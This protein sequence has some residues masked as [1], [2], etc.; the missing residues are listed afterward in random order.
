MNLHVTHAIKQNYSAYETGLSVKRDEYYQCQDGS[1]CCDGDYCR[2]GVINGVTVKVDIPEFIQNQNYR[3]SDIDAYGV[4]RI[5]RINKIY[6]SDSWGFE[7]CGGYY[8]EELSGV[9]I[10][11]EVYS[12]IAESVDKLIPLNPI[13]A[14]IELLLELEYEHTPDKYKNRK[15]IEAEVDRQTLGS[16]NPVHTKKIRDF[17]HYKNY[18][19]YV[20]LCQKEGD[21]FRIIDGHHRA[22]AAGDR[23]K[24]L[25]FE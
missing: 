14:K 10:K 11:D 23:V 3:F 13:A 2:C 4:D 12:S 7:K 17:E 16:S 18:P 1:N 6:E 15:W 8:G 21:S 25:Y 24:I 20:C 5:L 9:F 22:K 19:F